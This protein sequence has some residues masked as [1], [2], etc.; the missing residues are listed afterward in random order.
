MTPIRVKTAQSQTRTMITVKILST[1]KYLA[2][3][4]RNLCASITYNV[5]RCRRLQFLC[6]VERAPRTG[7]SKR[8]CLIPAKRSFKP[9]RRTQGKASK[10]FYA[11]IDLET[12]E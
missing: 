5:L 12:D 11:R 6:V 3:G 9:M 4:T 7:H 8:A 1:G 10:T 2:T